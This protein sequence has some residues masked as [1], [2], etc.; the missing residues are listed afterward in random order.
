MLIVD[1]LLA[2]RTFGWPGREVNE[3]RVEDSA[4]RLEDSGVAAS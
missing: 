4:K 3:K 1:A 2:E